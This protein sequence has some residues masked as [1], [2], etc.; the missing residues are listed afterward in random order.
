MCNVNI[1]YC[2]KC[3]II[4]LEDN[5]TDICYICNNEFIQ[6]EKEKEDNE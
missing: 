2:N 5:I 3:G 4:L 1:R 6:T